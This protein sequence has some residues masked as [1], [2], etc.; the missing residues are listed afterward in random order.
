M[1]G[2]IGALSNAALI[3]W[4]NAHRLIVWKGG[5]LFVVDAANGQLTATGLKAEKA[6]DVFLQ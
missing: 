6:E 1:V 2:H 4:V 3:G 5:E